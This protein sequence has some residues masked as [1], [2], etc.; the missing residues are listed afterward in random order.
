[1]AYIVNGHAVGDAEV[2]PCLAAAAATT[3]GW[4]QGGA[5]RRGAD[6]VP[7]EEA[8]AAQT[9]VDVLEERRGRK[10]QARR[11]LDYKYL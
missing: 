8:G 6:E 3:D 11:N 4:R 10:D 7:L 2:E 5:A 1:M 9:R